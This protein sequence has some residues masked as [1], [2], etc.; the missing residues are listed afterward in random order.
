MIER[1][2]IAGIPCVIYLPDQFS[3]HSKLPLI[4]IFRAKP[5]EW[6]QSRL[7]HS[8][9][10]RNVFTV[11]KDL[12][13]H[14][15][16]KPCG[17]VFPQTSNNANNEFYFA[18][19]VQ[20]KNLCLDPPEIIL[21]VDYFCDVFLTDLATK[22]P[23]DIRR[24]SLDGFSL[25]GFTSLS[26]S[27]SRPQR[28]VSTGS[29]DGSILDYEMDNKRINPKTQS[30]LTF[31]TFPYLYGEDPDEVAFRAQNPL[32]ILQRSDSVVP[33][34][35]FIMHSSEETPTSNK[36]RVLKFLVSL[37]NRGIVNSAPNALLHENSM[38]EWYWVDEY[39]FRSLPFHSQCLNSQTGIA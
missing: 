4:S 3:S 35:L 6:F 9:G 2:I 19:Q 39:L 22:Y 18:A 11:V 1:D 5:D 8:R 15:Y 20:Q 23:V 27:F 21:D 37:R 34:N 12:I 10:K 31:D 26:Y 38:H 17:F 29:F 16:L 7:D 32:D 28:F 33:E 13:D 30:D 14:D 36:P 24:V 25:G